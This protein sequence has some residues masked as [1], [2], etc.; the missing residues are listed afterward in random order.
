MNCVDASYECTLAVLECSTIISILDSRSTKNRE[1]F[2]CVVISTSL[3]DL[4]SSIY[5]FDENEI[6]ETMWHHQGRESEELVLAM[7]SK[8]FHID[9]VAPTNYVESVFS[10]VTAP[11]DERRELYR[12]ESLSSL[13][14]EN[15]VSFEFFEL[16]D[17]FFCFLTLDILDF[18]MFDG[19]DSMDFYIFPE[20][21]DIFLGGFGEVFFAI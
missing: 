5:L 4:E 2:L 20:P 16:L 11:L 12:I 9:A 17:Q 21:F 15:C 7:S 10:L 19:F 1:F 13:I 14:A 3:D 8:E 18:C 6:G